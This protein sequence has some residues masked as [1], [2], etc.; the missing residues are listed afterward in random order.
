M[1]YSSVSFISEEPPGKAA[2]DSRV[3]V[4]GILKRYIASHRKIQLRYRLDLLVKSKNTY[5]PACFFANLSSTLIQNSLRD[6]QH[7]NSRV[8]DWCEQIDR[9]LGQFQVS[10][11][12][13][14]FLD[15]TTNDSSEDDFVHMWHELR[16]L[17]T[18]LQPTLF[19][20]RNLV[21]F[22]LSCEDWIFE[23][24]RRGL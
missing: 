7:L 15:Q 10:G 1:V 6:D 5:R 9:S 3:A 24:E 23:A 14:S 11:T 19:L 21:I 13:G 8:A 12:R 2:C 4:A 22:R 16:E 17:I 18:Q 20:W